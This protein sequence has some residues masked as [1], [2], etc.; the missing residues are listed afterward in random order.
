MSILSFSCS[1]SND[2]Y[3]NAKPEIKNLIIG[4]DNIHK[5][6]VGSDLHVEV[7]LLSEAKIEK[8]I[9]IIHPEKDDHEHTSVETEH[10]EWDLNIV[11]DEFKGLKNTVFHKHLDVPITAEKGM[12]HFHISV[13]DSEGNKTEINDEFE[14]LSIEK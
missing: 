8:V 5:V 2:D 9:L 11:Y 13:V 1:D 14:V 12:Y 10:H 6:S 7:D 3:Q 4:H